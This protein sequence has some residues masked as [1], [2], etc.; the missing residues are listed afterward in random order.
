MARAA[1]RSKAVVLL[2]LISFGDIL[3]WGHDYQDNSHINRKHMLDVNK[4]EILQIQFCLPSF[5]SFRHEAIKN[6][7]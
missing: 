3:T 2:L 6:Q 1:V 7:V 4:T 5:P